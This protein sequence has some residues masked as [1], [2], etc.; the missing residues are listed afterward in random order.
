MSTVTSLDFL[1]L[2]TQNGLSHAERAVALVWFKDFMSPTTPVEINTICD[3]IERA[4][5]SKQNLSRL[6]KKLSDDPRILKDREAGFKINPL[7]RPSLDTLYSQYVKKQIDFVP[8]EVYTALL[9]LSDTLA[10]SYKQV[11][12][13]LNNPERVSW[14]G[15]AH[16]IRQI[17]SSLLHILAPNERV[18]AQ[19]WYSPVPRTSGP[20][21]SQRARFALEQRGADSSERETIEKID[22]F[23]EMVA[24]FV[25][26]T[27]ARASDAAHTFKPGQEAK[28]IMKYADAL[29]FDLLGLG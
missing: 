14:A 8:N 23:D 11:Q 29:I 15:T 19:P 28:R 3:E 26:V 17:L 5:Y 20:T 7:H 12:I 16:E 10:A 24:D 22:S 13:D 9:A 6:K 18:V 2:L 1:K 25:R 21:Q 27:Y 4:G